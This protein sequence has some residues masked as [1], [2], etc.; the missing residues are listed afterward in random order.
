[1][2]VLVERI[3]VQL[4]K[5]NRQSRRYKKYNLSWKIETRPV[6]IRMRMEW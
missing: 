1:M 5:K 4:R 6:S 2:K 3:R